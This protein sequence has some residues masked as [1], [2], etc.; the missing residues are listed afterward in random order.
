MNVDRRWIRSLLKDSTEK[1]NAGTARSVESASSSNEL[2]RD[3]G[4]NSIH[5]RITSGVCA[6]M[7]CKGI[8]LFSERG[9]QPERHFHEIGLEEPSG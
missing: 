2:V 6:R 7:P 1:K 4:H 5:M 9:D 8:F 3:R